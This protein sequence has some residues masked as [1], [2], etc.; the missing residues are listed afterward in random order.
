VQELFKNSQ[1]EIEKQRTSIET[2]YRGL[3]QR[4]DDLPNFV[5]ENLEKR[6]N[7]LSAQLNQVQEN[8]ASFNRIDKTAQKT[9]IEAMTFSIGSIRQALDNFYK[10]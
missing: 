6:K 7:G 3:R 1:N 2:E 5:S 10:G 4:F 9:R 8:L